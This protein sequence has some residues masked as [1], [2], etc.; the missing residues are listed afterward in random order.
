MRARKPDIPYTE[1]L[2]SW[3]EGCPDLDARLEKWAEDLR[4][5]FACDEQ[6]SNVQQRLSLAVKL[7]EKW[8]EASPRVS[9]LSGRKH[10]H[11]I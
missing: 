3:L 11:G 4:L 7:Y 5:F 6:S 8:E 10:W 2:L 1:P 9:L